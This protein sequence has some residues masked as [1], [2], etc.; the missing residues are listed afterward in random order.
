MGLI[1]VPLVMFWIL[2]AGKPFIPFISIAVGCSIGLAPL[3]A[4]DP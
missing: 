3:Y 2:L 1:L 4:G